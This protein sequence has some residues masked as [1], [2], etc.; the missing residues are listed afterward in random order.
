MTAGIAHELGRHITDGQCFTYAPGPGWP[1]SIQFLLGASGAPPGSTATEVDVNTTS[2]DEYVASA[3]RCDAFVVYK[4]DMA[5]VAQAF[6][7]P[8]IYQPYFQAVADWVRS[9]G[10]GYTLDRTWSFSD[11][12]PL[13]THT[14]GRYQG[15]FLT[16]ELYLRG[17][18]A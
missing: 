14:L 3:R 10:S 13:G 9:P 1:A 12:P 15:I 7:A 11:L 18:A 8:S 4:Q 16:V 6:Y 17:P 5:T 2:I